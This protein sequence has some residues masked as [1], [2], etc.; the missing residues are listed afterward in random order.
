MYLSKRHRVA[1][2]A[3]V[4]AAI[5]GICA[6]AIGLC[7]VVLAVWLPRNTWGN[8]LPPRVSGE[9]GILFGVIGLLVAVGA[10]AVRRRRARRAAESADHS[11]YK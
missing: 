11:V 7:A 1:G 4:I 9:I 10:I 5:I 6:A 3:G 8:S 2:V